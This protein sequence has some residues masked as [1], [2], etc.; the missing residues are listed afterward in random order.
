MENR[1]Y[2][3]L[4]WGS[5]RLAPIRQMIIIGRPEPI[6]PLNL[7][8]ILF[9]LIVPIILSRCPYY[10]HIILKTCHDHVHALNIRDTRF[11]RLSSS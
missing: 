9:S 2:V 4:M 8:I 10:S 3:L 1:E 11:L 7:P 5:L 6:M